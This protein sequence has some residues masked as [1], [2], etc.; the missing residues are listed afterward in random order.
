M[1]K[2]HLTLLAV[3]L[4]LLLSACHPGPTISSS[5]GK[6]SAKGDRIT[7]SATG[8]PTAEISSTGELTID[9]KPVPTA[10][11]QRDLLQTYQREFNSM[12]EQGLAIGKRGAGLAGKAV[13]AAIKGAMGGDKEKLEESIK[14]DARTIEQEALRL[15]SNLLVI[16]S[17]QDQLA[18]E[19]P[20]FKPYATIDMSD[21]QDCE[22]SAGDTFDIPA[23]EAADAV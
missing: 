6:V 1:H 8:Q 20:A 12:S 7:L 10:A 11:E 5:T 23:T 9:G 21:V 13:G 3:P 19:L 17:V 2:H 4:A 14:A 18:I 16:R 22:G 15:C